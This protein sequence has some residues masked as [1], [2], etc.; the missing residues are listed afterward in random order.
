MLY[1]NNCKKFYYYKYKM[2]RKIL[3]YILIPLFLLLIG[4]I[5]YI[6]THRINSYKGVCHP[7]IAYLIVL[8]VRTCF[9]N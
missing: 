3:L 4:I 9:I 8:E 1:K 5:I 6:V 7:C 2:S